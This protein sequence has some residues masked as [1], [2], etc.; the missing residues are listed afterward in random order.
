[1]TKAKP[2][3]NCLFHTW[4]IIRDTGTVAYRRCKQCTHRDAKRYSKSTTP[5]IDPSWI[6]KGTFISEHV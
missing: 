2:E 3:S 1:M 4:E 6:K 5:V